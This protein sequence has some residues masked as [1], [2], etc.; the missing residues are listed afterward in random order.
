LE[1]I[2]KIKE[3]TKQLNAASYEYYNTVPI[4]SDNEWDRL[5]EELKALENET[6]IIYPNSPTQNVGY[7]ILDKIEK[8]THNHPML[9]LDKCHS[10]QELIDFAGDKDCILSVKCDGLTTSLHYLD[11]GLVGAETRGNGMEGGNVLQNVLTIKNVPKT[12]PY[13]EELIIDGETIIDWN[14]FNKIN[15]DLPDEQEKFKHPRNLVSGSLNVLDTKIA[16]SRNMRFIAWRV[17]KGLNSESV[18]FALKNAEKLGFETVPM[19][20]YTNNSSD[21]ENISVMLNDLQDKAD[22][23]GIP[24]DGAVMTYDDIEYGNSLGRTEKFF[25]HSI[26]YKYEQEL[27]ETTLRNIEWQTSKTGL[28]N[29]IA[30]FNETIIDGASVTKATL[31]NISYIENLQLGIGDIIQVY[32]ANQIIPKV[33]ENLTRSN[34]WKL[35]DKCPCC[36]EGVEMHNKNGSKTLHCVNPD[37]KAKLLGKLTHFASKNAANIDI[38]SEQTLQKF[39]D[40]GWLNKFQDIYHLSDHKVEMYNLDGFGRKSVDKLLENIEKSRDIDL[41]HFLYSLSIPLIGK[42]ASKDIARVCNDNFQTFVNTVNL[43]T[44]CVF[45][46]IDGFGKEMN[47]SLRRW[48]NENAEMC[49]NLSKEFNFKEVKTNDEVK[50]TNTDLSGKV[51]VITGDLNHYKNRNELIEVIE[52]LNGKVTGSV[53]AKTDFLI[54]NNV[55]SSSSKNQKA[56]K[57]NI[58]IITEEEFITMISN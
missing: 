14:T 21:K 33:H 25:R 41:S 8:V 19:W 3:L 34:T 17:I 48:W 11:G 13:K 40:L 36:G 43:K 38:L 56:Q 47:T 29:P 46:N 4:M 7:E 6:G 53:S 31:H 9:S 37:C 51:F 55:Q 32:K 20:T 42:T 54:N 12:I 30:V 26:A 1:K 50:N 15:E 58:P 18:F 49:F 27:Y 44:E 28:I 16:A 23:L 57:L 39:I 5:Y 24:Y 52:G 10:E 35:P 2:E 22:A 45:T